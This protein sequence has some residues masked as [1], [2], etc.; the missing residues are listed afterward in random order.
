MA[1]GYTP[2]ERADD[3][4]SGG[5]AVVPPASSS[6][7]GTEEL[8][9]LAADAP[10]RDAAAGVAGEGEGEGEG[11]DAETL[12]DIAKE[13]AEAALKGDGAQLDALRSAELGEAAETAEQVAARLKVAATAVLGISG[14][15]DLLEQSYIAISYV[16]S[17]SLFT[18]P[19]FI[20]WPDE[21]LGWFD[22]LHSFSFGLD[23]GA[24]LPGAPGL[25]FAAGLLPPVLVLG[26][27]VYILVWIQDEDKRDSWVQ[28]NVEEDGWRAT[29]AKLL[30]R[31]L[32]APLAVGALALGWLWAQN[33]LWAEQMF[34]G[35]ASGSGQG[36]AMVADSGSGSSS[37]TS[38]RLA[39]S[40]TARS[41]KSS[42]ATSAARRS[43]R[44]NNSGKTTNP[45]S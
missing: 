44:S 29:R 45:S 10:N 34:D 16:Q 39:G 2:L 1:T 24:V 40:L 21:W 12:L 9:L 14:A 18:V 19:N 35:S 11:E 42:M 41:V 22:W 31:G 15:G 6:P 20:D 33:E 7:A 3:L 25:A 30:R 36:D 38:P 32:V 26:R 43:S 8:P 4:E 17:F 5:V 28:A 37:S 13:K 27:A 23:F